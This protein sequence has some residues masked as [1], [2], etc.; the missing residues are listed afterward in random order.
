MDGVVIQ[1]STPTLLKRSC[2]VWKNTLFC[3][4]SKRAL[5]VA[6]AG[7]LLLCH[8]ADANKENT[9]GSSIKRKSTSY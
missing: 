8:V 7:D 5:F 4:K 3:S 6:G 2:L 9:E 1:T